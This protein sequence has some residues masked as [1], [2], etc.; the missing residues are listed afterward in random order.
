MQP[1][2]RADQ[3]GSQGEFARSTA[4]ERMQYTFKIGSGGALKWMTV[5]AVLATAGTADISAGRADEANAKSLLKAMSDYLAAQN[6]ISFDYESDLEIV[7]TQQ[8]K[9]ALASSGTLTVNRPNKLHATR[10]GGF[11]NVEI[12]FDG[13]TLTL[14]G[15]NA[16]LYA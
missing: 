10:T 5:L 7:S 8:Q 6:A 16:N 15:K 3:C 13:K 9:V 12:V 2:G 4:E 11:A 14:V 1:R